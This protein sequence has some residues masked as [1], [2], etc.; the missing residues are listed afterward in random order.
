METQRA[1]LTH[2]P[3]GRHLVDMT[4]PVLFGI[5]TMMLQAFA[6]AYFIGM[7]GDRPLAALGFAF[8]ILMIVTS[9]AIGLGAGTSSVV[10]RAIGANDGRRARRL[11]TDSLIL[12]FLITAAICLVGILTIEPLFLRMGAPEDMIP[13]ISGYMKILYVG[14]PFVVVGMV[15]MSSMRATGDTRLPSLLMVIASIANVILDPILIFGLGPFPE[16]GLDGAA[17]AALISRAAIFGGTLYFMRYRLDLLSFNAP[18]LPELKDSW[19]DILHVGIPA[20]GTNAII[21]I[22]T[23]LITAMLASY[24]PVAVAGF[25]VASRVE[26][27][28][29]VMFY[30]LSAI[31]GPFVGQ[32]MAAGEADRIFRALKLCTLFCLGTGVAI[33]IIL[34]V[35]SGFL[36]SLFSDNPAVTDVTTL[37]LLIAPVSYGAY[38]MVMVMNA[39]FNGMGKPIPAV[40]ISVARMI[41][42]YLPLAYLLNRMFGIPGIFAAYAAANVITGIIAYSWARSSVT[43]QCDKHGKPTLAADVA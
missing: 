43:E 26:S 9:V 28:M 10:A 21:P 35:L 36:P 42:I 38:G 11:S 8:P 7:V 6:D 12:S 15:G 1:R 40:Y 31:I 27:L 33:A 37:F 34:A 5:F 19:R 32:N 30:A 17:M 4:V 29:L 20:A 18:R 3:V 41:A 23:A 2:G 22:A 16:M 24:G 14:V 25:S 39:S 13:M